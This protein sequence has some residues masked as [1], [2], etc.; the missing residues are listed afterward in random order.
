MV[1]T[2]GHKVKH[3][4]ATAALIALTGCS[5]F[6]TRTVT[7]APIPVEC[8]EKVPDRPAMP[9][10]AL[11][12]KPTVDQLLKHQD[13]EIVVREAYEVQLRTA[14]VICTTPIQP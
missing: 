8:R 2:E 11:T 9:T 3:I 7:E 4:A 10:E 13:A 6:T 1:G 14:L 5:A 12:T